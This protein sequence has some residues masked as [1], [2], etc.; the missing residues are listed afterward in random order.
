MSFL[1]DTDSAVIGNSRKARF[2]LNLD[3]KVMVA[4]QCLPKVLSSSLV[5]GV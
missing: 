3:A 1:L 4:D 5:S 2:T